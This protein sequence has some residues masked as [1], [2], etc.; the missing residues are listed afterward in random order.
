MWEPSAFLI[1]APVQ[2]LA[3]VE[4][5]PHLKAMVPA[6]TFSTPQNFFYASGTW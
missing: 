4:S 2:W 6:M 1:P 5:P 3:A